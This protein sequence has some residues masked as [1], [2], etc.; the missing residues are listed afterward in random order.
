MPAIALL[1][2]ESLS[3]LL[4][5]VTIPRNI[6]YPSVDMATDFPKE[7]YAG[8][9]KSYYDFASRYY[10][11]DTLLAGSA[12]NPVAFKAIYPIHIFDIETE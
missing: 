10:G 9:C 7:Q 11:I 6:E 2:K 4:K 8:V 3:W 1:V 12:V 5:V